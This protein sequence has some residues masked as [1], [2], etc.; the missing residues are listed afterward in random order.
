MSCHGLPEAIA[1]CDITAERVWE[2]KENRFHSHYYNCLHSVY[3][4]SVFFE[5]LKR[6]TRRG[7]PV[8]LQPILLS[9]QKKEL[10]LAAIDAIEQRHEVESRLTLE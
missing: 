5:G 6:Q 8:Q 9:R 7:C 4:T 3:N 10:F 2:Q 1:K